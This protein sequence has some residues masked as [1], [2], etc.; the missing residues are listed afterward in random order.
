[1]MADEHLRKRGTFVTVNHPARGPVVMPGW[2][3]KMSGSQVKVTSS[4]LLGAHTADVLAEWLDW[5]GRRIEEYKKR[6]Q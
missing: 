4:P 6:L 1:L 5:D 3:V 2:P